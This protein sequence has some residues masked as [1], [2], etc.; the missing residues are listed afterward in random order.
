MAKSKANTKTPLLLIVP[1]LLLAGCGEGPNQ[2]RDVY[3]SKAACLEDWQK[4]ELCNEM[5]PEDAEAGGYNGHGSSFFYWGPGYYS[6]Y[7]G[8]DYNG[9]AITPTTNRAVATPFVVKPTSSAAAKS[10]PT[11][12]NTVARGGFG[13]TAKG[14]SGGS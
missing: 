8:V 7:R 9:S 11:G 3:Q 1:A 12:V 4:S 10:N 5:P 14:L 6:G 2:Q 13:S